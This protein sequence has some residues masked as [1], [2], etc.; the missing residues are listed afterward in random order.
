MFKVECSDSGIRDIIVHGPKTEISLAKKISCVDVSPNARLFAAVSRSTIMVG[1]IAV[2]ELQKT[3]TGHLNDVTVVQFFP[4]NLVLLSAGADF[5]LKI[6][7]VLDG[8]NPVT[9]K[10]HKS[11][12]TSTA[13]IEKGRNILSSSRDGTIKLWNC[14]TSSVIATLGNYKTSVN[15]MILA[16]LPPTYQPAQTENLE[17]NEVGTED[18]LV[19]VALGDGSIHGIHL[20]T[21]AELFAS[22]KNEHAL[23]ALAYDEASS[24]VFTGNE[25]GQI[26]IYALTRGLKEPLVKWQRNKSP[27]TSLVL[28]LSRNGE[29]VLCI[30][31][32]DGG[33]YQTSSLAT[34]YEP[35]PKIYVEVEYTGNDLETISDMKVLPSEKEGYQ[36]IVCSVRDGKVKIY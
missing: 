23:T 32:A 12:I 18:K 29:S 5:Q 19:L 1:N 15:K 7:S 25:H 3:L 6:W 16:K 30:S 26:C 17:P 13:I 2:G 34:I 35:E 22:Q 20:G 24:L 10:G 31:S 27:I 11:A 4:S 33:L 14:G 28:K 36:H 9:L 21:R 8:S